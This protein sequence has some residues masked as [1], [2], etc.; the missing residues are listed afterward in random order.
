MGFGKKKG[1]KPEE[2]YEAVKS[3]KKSGVESLLAA[4]C[5][6]NAFKDPFVSLPSSNQLCRLTRPLASP[7]QSFLPFKE[8]YVHCRTHWPAPSDRGRVLAPGGQQGAD[9]DHRLAAVRRRQ[10]Q[11]TEQ[12]VAAP[13]HVAR[14]ALPPTVAAA[15][16]LLRAEAW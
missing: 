9:G 13:Q 12:G 15:R 11:P 2:I 3:N 14:P 6:P 4:K 5:D 1:P 10:S 8:L 7:E 16:C